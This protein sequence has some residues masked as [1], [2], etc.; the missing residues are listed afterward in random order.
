MRRWGLAIVLGFALG[1]MGC[2]ERKMASGEVGKGSSAMPFSIRGVSIAFERSPDGK[3]YPN[4]VQEGYEL[5]GDLQLDYSAY[6]GG[7]PI[8]LNHNDDAKWGAGALGQ[9]VLDAVANILKDPKLFAQLVLIP[10]EGPNPCSSGGYA[11]GLSRDEADVDY[12]AQEGGGEAFLL[13]DAAFSNLIAAFEKSEGRP[14]RPTDL[15]QNPRA[16]EPSGGK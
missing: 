11:L 6:F 12:C 15:P 9:K 4:Q 10:D 1:P 5:G 2:A 14:L 16:P 7:M 13:L 3:K 8:E